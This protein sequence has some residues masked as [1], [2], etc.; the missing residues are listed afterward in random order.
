[1]HSPSRFPIWNNS[2]PLF[3]PNIFVLNPR[4]QVAH[5]AHQGAKGLCRLP[6]LKPFLFHA[7]TMSALGL[8]YQP[9]IHLFNLHTPHRTRARQC[10]G[11]MG[12]ALVRTPRK[13][14]DSENRWPAMVNRKN[15]N[16]LLVSVEAVL[17]GAVGDFFSSV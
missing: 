9:G 13:G 8:A 12:T 10:P 7:A 1:M 14:K 3:D 11:F 2:W 16:T 15:S 4:H 17:H 5:D 6:F